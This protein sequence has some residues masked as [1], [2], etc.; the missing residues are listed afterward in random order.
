VIREIAE[1]KLT[2][3][4]ISGKMID[5]VRIIRHEIVPL[6]G[7]FE[8]RIAGQPSRYFYWDSVPS[9]RLRPDQLTKE[10]ALAQAQALARAERDKGG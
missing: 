3:S 8:V 1:G 6:C 10:E 4:G 7:S 5:R 2:F 9:R